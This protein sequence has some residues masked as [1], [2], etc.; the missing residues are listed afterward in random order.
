MVASEIYINVDEGMTADSRYQRPSSVAIVSKRIFVYLLVLT[1]VFFVK[2][3][4]NV[5]PGQSAPALHSTFSTA[6]TEHSY[7]QQSDPHDLQPLQQQQQQ[8]QQQQNSRKKPRILDIIPFNDELDLLEIRLNELNPVVDTFVIIE[9]EQ[10]FSRKPKPLY[11][12]ANKHRFQEFNNKIV[13]ITLPPMSKEEQKRIKKGVY[14]RVGWQEEVFER[15]EGLRQ[16]IEKAQP[17]EGDW[18]IISDL[19]EI[20]RKGAILALQGADSTDPD[21]RTYYSGT[22]GLVKNVLPQ[23]KDLY[24]FHCQFFEFSYEYRIDSMSWFGPVVFRYWAQDRDVFQRLL[25]HAHRRPLPD[26][27]GRS[28]KAFQEM[29]NKIEEPKG[30]TE[31]QQVIDGSNRTLEELG[32]YREAWSNN[33]QDGGFRLRW[34][35]T[36][37]EVAMINDA[38]WHCTYCQSNISQVIYKLQ[39]SSHLEFNNEKFTSKKWIITRAKIG[40]D[41]FQRFVERLT[42]LPDNH[43][44]P[45]YVNANRERFQ[46]L[47]DIHDKPNAGFLDVNPDDPFA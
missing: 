2:V 5:G 14:T 22:D 35:R 27:A 47:L 17:Q 29:Y 9:S 38:C 23:G 39:S 19:D 13:H 30:K 18:V 26:D 37:N 33:W 28:A 3:L 16:A 24:R 44:V 10:T 40:G 7:R 1:T 4:Y 20:P 43:D 34:L 31:F 36:R 25:S 45:E 41:L 42:Y 11:Y 8:Q 46:Y 6:A 15:N 32:L 21:D 12:M